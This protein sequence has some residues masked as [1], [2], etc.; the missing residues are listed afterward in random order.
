MCK[1]REF[2]SS[3]EAILYVTYSSNSDIVI[4]LKSL[5]YKILDFNKDGKAEVDLES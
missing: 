3:S 5:G 4:S 1:N 2:D